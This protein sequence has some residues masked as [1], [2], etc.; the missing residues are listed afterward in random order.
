[1]AVGRPKLHMS[2]MNALNDK[3]TT[4]PSNYYLANDNSNF[5]K[6]SAKFFNKEEYFDLLHF[7]SH[8]MHFTICKF[9]KNEILEYFFNN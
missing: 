6:N 4:N 1:M 9:S 3:K 5:N 2:A 8:L 7:E